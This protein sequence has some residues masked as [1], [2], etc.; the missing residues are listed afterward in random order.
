PRA[1]II[2]RGEL[3]FCANAEIEAAA[4]SKV[5][6][7]TLPFTGSVTELFVADNHA[8]HRRWQFVHFAATETGIAKHLFEFSEG[9][10]V[11]RWSA[12]QHLHAEPGGLWRRD[13][14]VVRDKL[15]RDCAPTVRQRRVNFLE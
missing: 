13:A 10:R 2:R 9:I 6:R 3:S 11:S 1:K 14:I 12:A 15:Q 4:T 8:F 7:V 5:E